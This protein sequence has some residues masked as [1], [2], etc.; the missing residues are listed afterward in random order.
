MDEI[1]TPRT[2]EA[3]NPCDWGD[4]LKCSAQLERELTIAKQALEEMQTSNRNMELELIQLK[5][6]R[7]LDAETVKRLLP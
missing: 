1:P 3:F 5:A 6:S 4:L 7:F 2:D